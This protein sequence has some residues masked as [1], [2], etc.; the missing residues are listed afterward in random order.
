MA[1]SARPR[2]VDACALYAAHRGLGAL[3]TAC[4]RTP[5]GTP[6]CLDA[7]DHDPIWRLR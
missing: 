6:V 7:T 1:R 2:R 3:P 5:A 4:L